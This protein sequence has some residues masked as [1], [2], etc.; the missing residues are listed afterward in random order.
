MNGTST[1][2]PRTHRY[3]LI[4]GYSVRISGSV[5]SQRS[6]RYG[7]RKSLGPLQTEYADE[8]QGQREVAPYGSNWSMPTRRYGT[9]VVVDQR[10]TWWLL[11]LVGHDLLD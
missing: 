7:N 9:F 6:S 5:H 8:C 4:S 3:P 11:A 2:A 1:P 10:R